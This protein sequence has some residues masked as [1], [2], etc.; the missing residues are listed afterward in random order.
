MNPTEPLNPKKPPDLPSIGQEDKECSEKIEKMLELCNQSFK[1]G[2]KLHAQIALEEIRILLPKLKNKRLLG[3]MKERRDDLLYKNISFPLELSDKQLLSIEKPVEI[4]DNL[5]LCSLSELNDSWL[6]Q[7]YQEVSRSYR[8]KGVN[9][10]VLGTMA[11][12]AIGL[13]EGISIQLN[14]FEDR[15]S[16]EGIPE[17]ATLTLK[18]NQVLI[19]ISPQEK[20]EE[21][22]PGEE[23]REHK[24]GKADSL[25]NATYSRLIAAIRQTNSQVFSGEA[26]KVKNDYKAQGEHILAYLNSPGRLVSQKNI[27]LAELETRLSTLIAHASPDHGSALTTGEIKIKFSPDINDIQTKTE[28][29]GD[30]AITTISV[31]LSLLKALDGKPGDEKYDSFMKPLLSFLPKVTKS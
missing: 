3:Q 27:I 13:R 4:G 14:K 20:K 26:E 9:Y 25:R 5:W 7:A 2:K 28:T 12:G 17:G 21:G 29:P 24:K 18:G 30:K 31:G 19:N 23:E 15:F 16:F 10:I 6:P 11:A 8:D 22:F 1:E